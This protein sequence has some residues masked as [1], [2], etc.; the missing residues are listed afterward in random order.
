MA[1]V[2]FL[3][4]YG[5][6]QHGK[7]TWDQW[8]GRPLE[9]RIRP[10]SDHVE[11][12]ALLEIGHWIDH[13]ALGAPGQFASASHPVLNGWRAAVGNSGKVQKLEDFRAAGTIPFRHALGRTFQLPVR[14]Y[15]EYLLS[16]VELFSRSYAQFIAV[17]SDDRVLLRQI[18]FASESGE[19]TCIIPRYWAANDF[20]PISRE[21][22]SAIIKIGWKRQ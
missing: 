15:V 7:F 16:P 19:P 21:I 12:T 11:L 6:E 5:M 22:R 20:E 13:Q 17:E 2:V 4:D 9:I 10:T 1:P 18:A 3:P 8:T 14:R